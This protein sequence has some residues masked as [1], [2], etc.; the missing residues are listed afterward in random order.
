MNLITRIIY[1]TISG[2][3]HRIIY[4]PKFRKDIKTKLDTTLSKL[5]GNKND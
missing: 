5:R 3:I 1:N 4:Y 2:F